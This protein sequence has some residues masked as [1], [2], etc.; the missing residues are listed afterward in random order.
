MTITIIIALAIW[1]VLIGI[2]QFHIT[3]AEEERE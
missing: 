3:T 1:A 2:Q